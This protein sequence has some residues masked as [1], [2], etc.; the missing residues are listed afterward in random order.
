M[1]LA[2]AWAWAARIPEAMTGAVEVRPVMVYDEAGAGGAPAE[3]SA[4]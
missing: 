4:S 2:V 3:A 1:D